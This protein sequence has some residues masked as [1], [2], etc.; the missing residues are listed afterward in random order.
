MAFDRM[1]KRARH[2]AGKLLLAL[3]LLRHSSKSYVD[4]ENLSV[5]LAGSTVARA[6]RLEVQI[7][8]TWGTVCDDHFN[9]NAATVACYMFG[10]GRVGRVIGNQYGPGSGTIWL[11]SVKCTGDETS[12]VECVHDPFGLNNCKHANDVSISCDEF[13]TTNATS[14]MK[15][16]RP[17]PPDMVRVRLVDGPDNRRGRLEVRYRRVWGTVCDDDFDNAD[18]AVACHMLGLGRVGW[19][20][21][22]STG[23][24]TG[25]IWLDEMRCVGDEASLAACPHNAWGSHDC[26]HSEDVWLNCNDAANAV[27]EIRLAD[28]PMPNVGR[29]EIKYNGVWGTV[30]DD[31]FDNADARVACFMLGYDRELGVEIGNQYGPGTGIIWM[32][33]VACFGN[34]SSLANCRHNGWGRHNCGHSEDVSISCNYYTG[35][36]ARLVDGPDSRRGRVEVLYNRTWG[37]VCDDNFDN[38]D[39][40]V[41]CN[42]LGYGRV[43]QW[44]LN[45]T[46]PG[47]GQIWLDE[48]RCVGDEESLAVCP[49]N[50]WGSHNCNHGEDVWLNCNPSV[51][52][53]PAVRLRNGSSFA[54]KG[55]LEVKYNDV[56]GTVCDDGFGNVDARVACY[57][58][59]YGRRGVVL[60]NQYG[61]GTGIIWMDDVACTGRESSLANCGHNG[62]GV[63]NCVHGEDVS[64]SCIDEI[65]GVRLV[66]R[67][68]TRSGRLEVQYNGVWGTVCDNS[69]D[70]ADTAVVCNMLGFGRVGQ[71]YSNPAVTT[72]RPIWLDEMQC[73]GDETSL[74][75]CHH[76]RCVSN[77]CTHAEDVWLN[78]SG[79][80]TGSIAV[81][82]VG[83]TVAGSGRLEIRYN[84]VWGTVCDTR[85]DN[86]DAAVACY[87]LG[88]GRQG[89]VA[90]NM[91]GPGIGIIWLDEM[92]CTGSETSL[93]H[94]IH[95]SWGTH[96]CTHSE[97]VS[98]YCGSIILAAPDQHAFENNEAA[99]KPLV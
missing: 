74:A 51:T 88:Y 59:G 64:I 52:T 89:T 24:E 43:G 86:T 9:D 28:G 69:F 5:R 34:E 36:R 35:I 32:D 60:N 50:P 7:K 58:L 6:G 91:F 75:D 13:A 77:Y 99:A 66:R 18:A 48:M 63:H 3:C 67:P 16:A 95:K 80:P 30:C 97:D 37:T 12:L 39:A 85:F 78:C 61:P 47:A 15:A 98:I 65:N 56:W 17:P 76:N 70:N 93:A 11:N 46:V 8:G 55:R 72:S 29:L 53:L 38:A 87:M 81:R 57:M 41:A 4:G 27:Q 94:C 20:Y 19:P 1:A 96:H 2:S 84:G 54:G 21:Y 31:S 62:W 90:G 83:S 71:M 68:N 82:L 45:R 73:V 25:R 42:M 33:D 26:D 44:Y 23:A 92:R 49:H 22:N 14:V 10:F 40:A 79:V